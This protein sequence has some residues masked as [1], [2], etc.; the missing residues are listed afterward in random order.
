MF[1]LVGVW[2]TG[3]WFMSLAAILRTPAIIRDRPLESFAYTC[4]MTV[5]PP[6]TLYFSAAQGSAYGLILATLLLPVC[7]CIFE[8][9]R[10][11]VPPEWKRR[12]HSRRSH[13]PVDPTPGGGHDAIQ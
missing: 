1:A 12:L 13:P 2:L 11:F 4:L 5:F 10:W 6:F 9:D 7:H 8:E 3:P